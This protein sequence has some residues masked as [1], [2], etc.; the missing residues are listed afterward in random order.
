MPTFQEH[1][2]YVREIINLCNISESLLKNT[3]YVRET[4]VTV[5]EKHM[6]NCK[7]NT[8]NRHEPFSVIFRKTLANCE[9]YLVVCSRQKHPRLCG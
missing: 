6:L 2:R 7:K 5:I 1:T 4:N 3:R 9:K 8:H